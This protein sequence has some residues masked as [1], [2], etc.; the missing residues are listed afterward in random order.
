[1]V[2]LGEE[3]KPGS[4]RRVAADDRADGKS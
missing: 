2:M 3:A 1:V 4:R